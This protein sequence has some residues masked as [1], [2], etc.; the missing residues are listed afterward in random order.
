MHSPEPGCEAQRRW[1]CLAW[2]GTPP[3]T[4]TT[5]HPKLFLSFCHLSSKSHSYYV[6]PFQLDSHY[7]NCTCDISTHKE[8]P[9]IRS[10]TQYRLKALFTTALRISQ[11][12]GLSLGQGTLP[13]VYFLPSLL[14]TSGAHLRCPA[15]LL[16][17]GREA[18]ISQPNAWTTKQLPR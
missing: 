12:F 8:I 4:P 11:P 6:L 18:R 14:A 16:K 10:S 2:R 15:L 17:S 7:C 1:Q 13:G 5:F 9:V 3:L